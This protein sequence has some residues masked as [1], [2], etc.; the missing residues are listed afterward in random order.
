MKIVAVS[1]RVD[2][3]A[4]RAERRDALD[5]Q[6]VQ[7]LAQAGLLAVPVPNA[8]GASS[9]DRE[10]TAQKLDA[11]LTAIRPQAIVL[12]GG[13][14][15]G[16]APERDA[17]EWQLLDWAQAKYMPVLAICRGMQM[18]GIWAGAELKPVDGHV[19]TRHPLH[20]SAGESLGTVNSYHRFALAEAPA[21]F[22]AL[23]HAADGT[24]EAM[25][26]ARLPWLAW[27]WH[28]ERELPFDKMHLDELNHLLQAIENNDGK[29]AHRRIA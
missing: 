5:Q 14:D 28:P 4:E 17:T 26:H 22:V 8:L 6:L 29:Y 24:L 1:Q 21:G 2:V 20:N 19:R 13:N 7:W 23:A 9:G 25:R 16:E 15:I 11:W 10:T 18:M 3:L 27:M 12:S